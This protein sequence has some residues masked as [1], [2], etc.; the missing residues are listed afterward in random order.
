MEK[1]QFLS[2][3]QR[4]ACFFLLVSS[5]VSATV[6]WEGVFCVGWRWC[7]L[8]WLEGIFGNCG[9]CFLRR[10]RCFLRLSWCFLRREPVFSALA[11]G[12]RLVTSCSGGAG[13]AAVLAG[14][15]ATVDWCFL[16]RLAGSSGGIGSRS[17]VVGGI[18]IYF[19]ISR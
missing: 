3:G 7:F 11:A 19:V 14:I 9:R 1:H 15:F 8:L 6:S 4:A 5:V 2:G 16:Q 18:P 12:G 17:Y 13:A 10:R